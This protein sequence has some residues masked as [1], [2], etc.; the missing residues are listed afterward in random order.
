MQILTSHGLSEAQYAGRS[1]R[2]I[3]QTRLVL[4]VGYLHAYTQ[5][6]ERGASYI[7]A[8]VCV[9]SILGMFTCSSH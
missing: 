1:L 4:S 5:L 3:I 2:L 7:C 6:L 9:Q 8:H